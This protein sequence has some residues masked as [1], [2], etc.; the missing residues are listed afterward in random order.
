MIIKTEGI[1]INYIKY[2]ES[3]IIIRI[4]TEKYG[5]QSFLLNG[6]RSVRSKKSIGNFQ[7][8]NVLELVAYKSPKADIYRLNEFK[9]LHLAT[10]FQLNFKKSAIVM[11]CTELLSKTLFHERTENRNLYQFLKNEIIIFD[12]LKVEFESFHIYFAIKYASYLGFFIKSVELLLPF[13]E[14][15]SS[16]LYIYLKNIIRSEHYISEPTTG[17][18]RS[19]A[20][21]HVINYYSLHLENFGEIKSL[22]ILSQVFK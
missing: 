12:K 8:L 14:N 20:L 22:R 13:K 21:K 9:I 16:P 1:V 15:L 11:F 7:S 2:K 5:F 6:V 10:S 19:T 4:L 3:S 18:L 17:T